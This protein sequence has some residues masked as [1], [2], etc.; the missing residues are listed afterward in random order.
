MY[1]AS[2]E[3]QKVLRDGGA[4]FAATLL[5]LF[6]HEGLMATSGASGDDDEKQIL[7][8]PMSELYEMVKD[9]IRLARV[10][11]EGLLDAV[12]VLDADGSTTTLAAE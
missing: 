2:N 9:T 12:I 3:T 10:T 4:R 8:V 6:V 7:G 1:Q 11:Q 5:I